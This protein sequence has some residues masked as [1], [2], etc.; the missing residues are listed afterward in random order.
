MQIGIY[1][2]FT[3]NCGPWSEA[4]S[5]MGPAA[6]VNVHLKDDKQPTQPM[7]GMWSLTPTLG[8]IV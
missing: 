2:I 6:R 5:M 4:I 1:R 8:L 7:A 3:Q